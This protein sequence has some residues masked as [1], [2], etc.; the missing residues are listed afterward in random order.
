MILLLQI[1]SVFVVLAIFQ[2][3]PLTIAGMLASSIFIMV[4][5]IST[6]YFFAY[7][8]WKSFALYTWLLFLL[9]LAFPILA[10]RIYYMDLPTSEIIIGGIPFSTL[11]RLSEKAYLLCFLLSLMDYARI[12]KAANKAAS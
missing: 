3:V 1:L 12:K 10:L 9:V 8:R 6:Y 11:H 2:L 5:M 4:A 7:L